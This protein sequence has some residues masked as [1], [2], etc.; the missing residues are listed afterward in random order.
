MNLH[1]STAKGKTRFSYICNKYRNR[2]GV[3]LCT[4]HYIR[5][6]VL[7][8]L[9]LDNLRKVIAY[10]QDYEDEFVQ[11]IIG[12]SMNEQAK[13]LATTKRQFEQQTQRINKI[14]AIIQQLY[15][16]VCCKG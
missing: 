15:E 5:D 1:H 2:R 9:V 13:Q 4:A 6:Y 7:E 16:D 8:D 12:R 3:Q 14:D 11:E 10:V